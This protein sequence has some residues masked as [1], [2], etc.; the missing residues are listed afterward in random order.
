MLL[1]PQLSC[2]LSLHANPD[3]FL[4][5]YFHCRGRKIVELGI[6]ERAVDVEN[7]E[8]NF[9]AGLPAAGQIGAPSLTQRFNGSV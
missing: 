8:I 1:F 9:P 6:D 7:K 2:F 3:S 4:A 5:V